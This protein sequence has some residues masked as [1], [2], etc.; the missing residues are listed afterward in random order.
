[1]LNGVKIMIKYLAVPW[2]L[3]VGSLVL[4]FGGLSAILTALIQLD[5]GVSYGDLQLTLWGGFLLTLAGFVIALGTAIY[6]LI[7]KRTHVSEN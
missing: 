4:V 2:N 7:K 6:A 5:R 1:M 3:L